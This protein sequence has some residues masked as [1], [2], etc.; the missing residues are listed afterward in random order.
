[1]NQYNTTPTEQVHLVVPADFLEE[2]RNLAAEN[3]R[4]L[5]AEI[6]IAM[7]KHLENETRK[8]SK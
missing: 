1:M 8:A 7:R 2:F 6:R 4:S 3:E 5:S